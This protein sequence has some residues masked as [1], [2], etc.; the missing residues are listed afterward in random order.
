MM[1]CKLRN[2]F[3][4]NLTEDERQLCGWVAE[5]A[6]IGIDRVEY[7]EVKAV[8]GTDDDRDI[9]EL[10][11]QMRERRDDIHKMVHSPI[12]HTIMPYFDVHRDA[13]CIW[14]DYCR[15]EM[16]ELGDDLLH[17]I[18]GLEREELECLTCAV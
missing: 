11:R 13:D 8:M 4:L 10:L 1:V 15:A 17:D 5:Q 12:V 2:A 6:R 9:T 7:A 16:E 14:D 18:E 3:E